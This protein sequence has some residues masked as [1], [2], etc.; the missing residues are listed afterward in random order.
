LGNPKLPNSHFTYIVH[1]LI[2]ILIIFELI[3]ISMKLAF[4]NRK[5]FKSTS[6]ENKIQSAKTSCLHNKT[7]N[8]KG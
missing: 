1:Q 8:T 7:K 5:T 2:A 6:Q 4:S 3:V